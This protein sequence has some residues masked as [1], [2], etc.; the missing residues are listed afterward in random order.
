MILSL[1]REPWSSSQRS[2]FL[3]EL[4]MVRINQEME[5]TIRKNQLQHPSQTSE[6]LQLFYLQQGLSKQLASLKGRKKI[7]GK[8]TRNEEIK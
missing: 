8:K 5:K 1:Q 6:L 3:E 2:R 4:K 7:L